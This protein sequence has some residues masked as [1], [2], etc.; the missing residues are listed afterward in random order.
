VKCIP[1]YTQVFLRHK[2]ILLQRNFH[3]EADVPFNELNFV[4]NDFN[5][6]G[7]KKV[8]TA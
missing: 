3:I 6:S 7:D 2:S 5:A 4:N 1:D 8:L